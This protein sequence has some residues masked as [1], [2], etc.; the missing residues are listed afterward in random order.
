M[1]KNVKNY[2]TRGLIFGGFGPMVAGIVLWILELSGV[3]VA[4]G[5]ADVLIAVLST[6]VL[7][8][9]QAGSS[10]FN[11]IEDWSI[12]KSMGLHFLS[13]YAVYVSCYLVNRWLP[14]DWGVIGVFTAI[15]FAVYL[16]I[17]LTVYTIV[18]NTS[19]KLNRS[20]GK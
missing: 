20:I 19:K 11:Q 7:A 8:F 15:F 2:L 16:V 4:L 14:F 5:G 10:V 12:A 3:D 1:N 9:V 13:L 18:R 6:Y 17:W